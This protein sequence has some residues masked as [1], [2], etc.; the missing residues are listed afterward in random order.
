M[1][2]TEIVPLLDSHREKIAN[3]MLDPVVLDGVL[4]RPFPKEE[5]LRDWVNE[6]YSNKLDFHFAIFNNGDH[7][8]CVSLRNLNALDNH[9]EMLIY[10]GE[11]RKDGHGRRALKLF[12]DYCFNEIKIH[13]IYAT[14]GEN[15]VIAR[16]LYRKCGFFEEG[17]FKD[18]FL[19]DGKYIN[20][21]KMAKIKG[22]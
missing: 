12:A 1:A 16:H 2:K 17:I 4:Q 10:L 14:V 8:G 7:I 19:L 18:A 6:F 20:V 5:L 11:Q 15:N 3:W 22:E 9:G 21:I 13:K